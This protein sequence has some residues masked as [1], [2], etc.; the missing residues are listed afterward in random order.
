MTA[1]NTLAAD[2]EALGELKTLDVLKL[3][4][5]YNLFLMGKL[6]NASGDQRGA[7]T[8]LNDSLVSYMEL[9]EKMQ[10]GKIAK[11]SIVPYRISQARFELAQI[12]DALE[13]AEICSTWIDDDRLIDEEHWL[14]VERARFSGFIIWTK[15]FRLRKALEDF[16]ELVESS[17]NDLLATYLSAYKN[18][19]V[20]QERKVVLKGPGNST[21][22]VTNEQNKKT[23][24]NILYYALDILSFDNGLSKLEELGFKETDLINLLRDLEVDFT[25]PEGIENSGISLDRADTIARCLLYLNK[26]N[27]QRD[28]DPIKY[29]SAFILKRLLAKYEY[30][31]PRYIAYSEFQQAYDKLVSFFESIIF[32]SLD[33]N[34]W[35]TAKNIIEYLTVT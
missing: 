5:A 16:P 6:K 18:T 32:E 31:G 29:L 19:I 34:S 12:N 20:V 8:D 28:T 9:Y 3:E 26:R 25:S 22:D 30:S 33:K 1:S 17:E 7:Y 11:Y 10:A 24:N 15:G 21:E 4:I 2:V 35:K 13:F 14:H 23:V 27:L